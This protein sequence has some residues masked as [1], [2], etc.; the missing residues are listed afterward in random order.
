MVISYVIRI[1]MVLSIVFGTIAQSVDAAAQSKQE[2]ER[3]KVYLK[4]L[5]DNVS[6]ESMLRKA[7]SIE[8]LKKYKVPVLE[9]LPAIE[10]V[11]DTK[12]R[13]RDE[14]A[15]RAIALLVVAVKGEGAK[16]DI[17]DGLVI[18]Y[19]VMKDFTPDER[20]FIKNTKPS[21]Q[22]SVKFVWRYE[23]Y[24][25]LL[26]ALGYTD[27]LSYPDDIVD[28]AK[29]V[30]IVGDTN[31]EDFIAHAKLRSQS[32]IVDAADLIYRYHWAIVDARINNKPA[33][34]GLSADVIMER[35]YVLNWLIGYLD[36]EWDDISTDT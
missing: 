20:A 26:W 23:C 1:M 11:S 8:I 14:I 10:P 36:Q 15:A 27:T 4:S 13:S 2:L 19:D 3:R 7:R 16:Q 6:Q 25:V 5:E 32:E 30:K 31:R 29:I 24:G 12:H 21:E 34:A 28:V 17:V 9:S 22:D 18:E 33:P 35:H